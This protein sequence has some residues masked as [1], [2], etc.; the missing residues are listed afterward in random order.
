MTQIRWGL[1][2]LGR[3]SQLHQHCLRQMTEVQVT[4]VADVEPD[5]ARESGASWGCASY[6]D[7]RDMLR[8][9]KLDAVTVLTPEHLHIEPVRGALLAGCHVFV[10]KPLA[11]DSGA[12]AELVRLAETVGSVL[13]VGHVCR[14]DPRYIA[15]KRAMEEMRIG[16]L[17]SIYARRNNPRD[18]F[19][20]YRRNDPVFILGIHDIDL[21]HWFTGS[22]VTEVFAVRTGP[23]RGDHDMLWATLMFADGTI[24]VI[25]NNWLVPNSAP[26]SEDIVMEVVGE[27]GTIH[28]RDPDQT[29]TF[30]SERRVTTP[31]SY[32]W[33][34]IHGRYVGAL[35][36]QLRH[37][38]E[39]V[40]SGEPSR[41]LRPADALAAVRVAEAIVRSCKTGALVRL[42]TD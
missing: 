21:M 11:T 37:F 6:T 36:E 12:G 13:M 28:Q 2:G 38:G 10:E 9:E 24:G 7:W 23:G 34:E 40:R 33:N 14:F 16:R 25:E 4:A 30:W 27:E 32:T 26:S 35:A 8:E 18:A 17:R 29:L 42:A 15:I 20:I 19:A 39:C 3:F 41:L 22:S 1:I 5:T 31:A